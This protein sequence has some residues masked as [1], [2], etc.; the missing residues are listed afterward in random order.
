MFAGYT[1]SYPTTIQSM[2]NVRMDSHMFFTSMEDIHHGAYY[3]L[4]QSSFIVSV[5]ISNH[6]FL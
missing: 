4:L 3:I 2:E 1:H 5:I 6:F